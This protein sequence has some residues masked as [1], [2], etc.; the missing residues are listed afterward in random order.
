M[1]RNHS[2]IL[3]VTPARYTNVASNDASYCRLLDGAIQSARAA[4]FPAK[5]AFDTS[6]LLRA[7]PNPNDYGQY[8][9]GSAF[10]SLNRFER[11]RKVGAVGELYVCQMCF[12]IS[13]DQTT[14][15]RH[16]LGI[17]DALQTGTSPFQLV[18]RQLAKH[19]KTPCRCPPGLQRSGAMAG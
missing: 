11:D 15:Y 6:N 17:R 14:D 18:L 8:T 13:A 16:L 5:N 9:A 12:Q 10:R 19:D 1:D 2:N 4:T 3:D 7:L